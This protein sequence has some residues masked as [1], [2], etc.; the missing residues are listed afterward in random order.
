MMAI[1]D[2]LQMFH[3]SLHPALGWG[4]PKTTPLGLDTLFKRLPNVLHAR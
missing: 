3:S 1:D 2:A 4:S